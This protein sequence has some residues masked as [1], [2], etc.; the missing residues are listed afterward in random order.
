M[1]GTGI[2]RKKGL[3][4]LPLWPSDKD[5]LCVN[6]YSVY[7]KHHTMPWAR[8]K[9]LMTM[10]PETINQFFSHFFTRCRTG[11]GIYTNLAYN[12]DTYTIWIPV[13]MKK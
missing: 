12:R 11:T 1:Y 2:R 8:V 6:Q 5:L 10:T 3:L 9:L 7:P 13:G 4:L